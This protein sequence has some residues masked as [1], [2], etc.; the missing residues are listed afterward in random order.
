MKKTELTAD[1]SIPSGV[2]ATGTEHSVTVKGSKGE[3][4][5]E[6]KHPLIK[7]K[8]DS[9]KISVTSLYASAREK[10]IV[11]TIESHITNMVRGVQEGH[12]YRLKICSGHFPMTVA[13]SANEFSVKNFLGEKF[14]RILA[15]DP[16]VKVSI[17]AQD[18]VVQ[19]PALEKVSQ[20]AANIEKLTMVRNRDRRIFQDGIY[21]TEKPARELA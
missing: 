14:P 2:T 9:Q 7:I 8:V 10:K 15:I 6:W 1:I 5:R 18:V 11:N 21:I 4:T 13:M 17:E 12:V 19:G 16:S 3:V 20:C